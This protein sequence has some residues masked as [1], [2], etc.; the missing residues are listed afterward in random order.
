MFRATRLSWTAAVTVCAFMF[1]TGCIPVE[2]SSDPASA[3]APEEVAS[4]APVSVHVESEP[5]DTYAQAEAL[6]IADDVEI[7]GDLKP[8]SGRAK[9]RDLFELG[10]V[11]AGDRILASLD[12]DP[13][14]DVVMGVLDG[15]GRLLGFVN[16]RS[17]T[18]GPPRIDVMIH[19]S[20]S[21]LYVIISTR[22]ALSSAQP[23]IAQIAIERSAGMGP[24]RP[25][26]VLL[27]FRGADNVR[28]GNRQPVDVPPF[29]AANI[30]TRYA[31]RTE[32]MINL[33]LE[34]VRTDFE[35]LHVDIYRSGD[36]GLPA[37]D[38][39][40]VYF[41]TY[42]ENLLGLADNID[43]FNE[44]R[45]QSAIIYTDTFALF[46]VL[47]PSIEQMAQALANVTS[48]EIGHLLGLRHTIDPAGIMDVTASARQMLQ[49]QYFTSSP[50]HERVLPTGIQDA[51]SMLAWT[52]GGSLRP[53]SFLEK[54]IVRERI[55]SAAGAEDDFQLP[56]RLFGTGCRMD[57]HH[58]EGQDHDLGTGPDLDSDL[59]HY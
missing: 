7:R 14:H 1:S 21:R 51:P 39:S 19:Q 27:E 50:L 53:R 4:G 8:A 34:K 54:L 12:V 59:S 22:T 56:M 44:D 6:I 46:N 9:D 49:D 24:F 37:G 33:M 2:T 20:S 36:P 38:Y 45:V 30:D 26:A 29:N 16:P 41:G 55:I 31:G 48:H 58:G 52:V 15:D 23:Y 5:N 35:G 47:N 17:S 18:S 25:Q 40:T 10:P 32:E 3:N 28:I 11:A 57:D 13:F 42:D 43:P